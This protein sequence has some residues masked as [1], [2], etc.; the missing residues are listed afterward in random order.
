MNVCE[1][2]ITSS[3]TST[4]DWLMLAQPS[5]RR[6]V[7]LEAFIAKGKGPEDKC[8]CLPRGSKLFFS[9][10]EFF[11]PKT[12][13]NVNKIHKNVFDLICAVWRISIIRLKYKDNNN[14]KQR[15]C[16][17][18]RWRR[19]EVASYL[20]RQPILWQIL[21]VRATNR[22][23]SCLKIKP[24]TTTSTLCLHTDFTE[25]G[26]IPD[27]WNN[28]N[29]CNEGNIFLWPVFQVFHVA[30]FPHHCSWTCSIWRLLMVYPVPLQPKPAKMGLVGFC[31]TTERRKILEGVRKRFPADV[32]QVGSKTSSFFQ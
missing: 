7:W 32:L 20:R 29:V 27:G 21:S 5:W 1:E 8:W 4:V 23:P 24:M 9:L 19:Q 22:R 15:N 28:L 17:R 10:K 2:V 14:R 6:G 26:E 31:W 12:E 25:W 3:W 18:R 11:S 30:S 16:G 13:L